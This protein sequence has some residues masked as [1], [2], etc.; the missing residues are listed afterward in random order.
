[1]I[2]IEVK[3]QHMKGPGINIHG[4]HVTRSVHQIFSRILRSNHIHCPFY[5]A[6]NKCTAFFQGGHDRPDDEWVFIEFWGSDYLDFVQIIRKFIN[7]LDNDGQPMP[8]TYSFPP[9]KREAAENIHHYTLAGKYIHNEDGSITLYPEDGDDVIELVQEIERCDFVI[10]RNEIHVDPYSW[11]EKGSLGVFQ[12]ITEDTTVP[13]FWQLGE[14][15][16]FLPTNKEQEDQVKD[17]LQVFKIA[18][19]WKTYPKVA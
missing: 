13:F 4:K 16:K 2:T 7:Y 12:M 8:I 19:T 10:H 1:M 17:L 9:E 14:D 5:K 3:P 11:E 15:L 6:R 18:Y